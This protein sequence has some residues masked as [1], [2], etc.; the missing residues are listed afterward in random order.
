MRGTHGEALACGDINLRTDIDLVTHVFRERLKRGD[1]GWISL[2]FCARGG[3]LRIVYDWMG[4]QA[5]VV[6]SL[7]RG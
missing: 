1:E 5:F 7:V 3:L 2:S 4:I 6:N